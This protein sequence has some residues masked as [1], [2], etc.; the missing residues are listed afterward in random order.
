MPYGYGLIFARVVRLYGKGGAVAAV[1]RDMMSDI[2]HTACHTL[3]A[4][5]YYK[6]EGQTNAER[7]CLYVAQTILGILGRPRF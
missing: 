2:C 7:M 6:T 1:F 5:E 3:P 4:R